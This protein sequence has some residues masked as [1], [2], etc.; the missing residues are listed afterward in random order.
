[1]LLFTI[2]I[3][4]IWCIKAFSGAFLSFW[5]LSLAIEYTIKILI[6]YIHTYLILYIHIAFILLIF[7]YIFT[8]GKLV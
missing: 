8:I 7:I 1:M 6:Y 2:L 3:I 4:S 5:S